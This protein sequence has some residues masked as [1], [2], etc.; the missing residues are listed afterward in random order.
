ML[1]TY[2]WPLIFIIL[3]VL[4]AIVI[5]LIKVVKKFLN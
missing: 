1:T 4:V 5:G 2:N 3:F